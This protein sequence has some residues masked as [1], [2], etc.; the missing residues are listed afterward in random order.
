MHTGK[1]S[2]K[3]QPFLRAAPSSPMEK[4]LAQFAGMNEA[5]APFAPDPTLPSAA[6]GKLAFVVLGMHRTGAASLAGTPASSSPGEP[7]WLAPENASSEPGYYESVALRQ[8][9]DDILS[10]AGAMWDDWRALNSS[11]FSS[12]VAKQFEEKAVATLAEELGAARVI[13]IDDPRIGRLMP[14]WSRVFSRAGYAVRVILPVRSPLEVARSFRLR[15]GFP[16]SKGLLL[17]LRH[18]LDAEASSRELPT[19][20]MDW[21][22]FVADWRFPT[23]REDH[24][25]GLPRSQVS[26]NA[27]TETEGFLTPR[28]NHTAAMDESLIVHP[29]VNEWVRDAYHAMSTL[30]ADPSSERA[31]QTLHDVRV[32]FEKASRIFGRILVDF[33]ENW[34]AA[35]REAEEAHS[36]S[37]QLAVEIADNAARAEPLA[38]AKDVVSAERDGLTAERD[39]IAAERTALAAQL[40]TACAERDGLIAEREALAAERTALAAQL[41]T[42]CAERDGLT[43]ERNAIA[44]ERAALAAQLATAC[45]ERDGLTA[46]RDAIA[47]ERAAL[48]AQLATACA[49]RDGLIAEREALA[50]ERTALAAQLAT[51]CAD[52]DSLAAESNTIAAERAALAAQLATVCADRDSLI[53]EREAIAAEHAETTRKLTAA[54]DEALMSAAQKADALSLEVRSLSEDKARL[55]S[56]KDR[57]QHALVEK[58]ALLSFANAALRTEL[59]KLTAL[60]DS[61]LKQGGAFSPFRQLRYKIASLWELRRLHRA[62]FDEDAYLKLYPDVAASTTG[63]ALHYVTSGRREGRVAV[64]RAESEPQ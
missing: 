37:E 45:A 1:R 62:R 7:E 30:V 27:V 14:F 59:L 58:T 21:A 24:A 40:A 19:A 3:R 11:W 57:A 46:E 56:E 61:P 49:E 8:I 35:R 36:K 12:G 25:I 39:A 10:S 16:I 54:N 23:A 5:G 53:A 15:D 50:A 41:A 29:D 34:S 52:R 2:R 64:F 51:A 44:A 6:S 13:I 48:A 18:A 32:E 33:E 63:A 20:V 42:A 22:D 47:A 60:P 38:A 43:A 9:N 26:D 4:E 31:R 17:W 55:F 28:S